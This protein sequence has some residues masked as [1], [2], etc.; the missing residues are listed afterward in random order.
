M[1]ERV[2][3]SKDFW[4]GVIFLLTG[5]STV[6]LGSNHPMGTAMR[7][8]PGYF[9]TILGMLLAVIGLA[10]IFR[11]LLQTG[12]PLGHLAW[13][14]IALVLGANVIFGLLLRRIGLIASLI[15]LVLMSAYGSRRFRWPAALALAVALSCFCAI[16]F[17][18]LLGLP[19]PLLGPWFGG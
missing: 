9:P 15:L 8:G 17:V 18:K 7:M 6:L 3:N 16:A 4:S 10:V 5:V 1:R 11:A 14:K 19:I 12:E 13:G 2:R